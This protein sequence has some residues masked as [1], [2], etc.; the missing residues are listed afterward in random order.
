MER[1]LVLVLELTGSDLIEKEEICCNRTV[2]DR[3]RKGPYTVRPC[4]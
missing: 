4:V 1:Q 2:F 3:L